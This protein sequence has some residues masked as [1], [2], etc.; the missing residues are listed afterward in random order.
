MSRGFLRGLE[1]AFWFIFA[2]DGLFS[3]L[4]TYRWIRTLL[5]LPGPEV[6]R[7]TVALFLIPSEGVL[8]V[9]GALQF[10]FGLAN[11]LR[12]LG[13][14]RGLPALPGRRGAERTLT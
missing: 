11:L 6:Y 9:G 1:A 13:L 14:I 2:L 4:F 10:A 7:L 3:A 8:R 5:R 12:T